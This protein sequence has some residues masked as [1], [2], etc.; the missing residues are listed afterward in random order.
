M[1]YLYSIQLG[2]LLRA[3]PPYANCFP[4]IFCE[5]KSDPIKYHEYLSI[6]S[7]GV[8]KLLRNTTSLSCP[9]PLQI[10]WPNE[11]AI[12]AISGEQEA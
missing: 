3:G 9:T 6:K 12:S 7:L 4:F 11:S 8:K 10:S 2:L 5:P 1:K